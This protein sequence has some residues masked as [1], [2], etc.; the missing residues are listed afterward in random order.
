MIKLR[1]Y[2][3]D[4]VSR[5][6]KLQDSVLIAGTGTGKTEMG[7]AV[8]WKRVQ[9]SDRCVFVVPRDNL[10]RQTAATM[11]RWGLQCGFVLGGTKENRQA[12]IQIISYQSLG[13]KSRD[14]S[15][16]GDFNSWIADE[17]HITGFCKSLEPY[18]KAAKF[19]LGLTAT[20]WQMEKRSLLEVFDKPIFAPQVREMIRAGHLTQPV[21]F[22]PKRKKR[23]LY[24][25]PDFIFDTWL[26]LAPGEPSFIF[27]DS[28]EQ[29]EAI[30]EYFQGQGYNFVSITSKTPT[31]QVEK[32]FIDFESGALDGLSSCNKLAEGCDIPRASTVMLTARSDSRSA[33]YQRIGRGLRLHPSKRFT[34]VIDCVGVL[35]KFPHPDKCTITELDFAYDD[36]EPGDFP[37]KQCEN[38]FGYCHISALFCPRCKYPFDIIGQERYDPEAVIRSLCGDIE[39]AAIARYHHLLLQDFR[40]NTQQ[41]TA[42]FRQQFRYYPY[43]HWLVD[44]KLPASMRNPAVNELWAKFKQD[45]MDTLPKNPIQL[46]L[47]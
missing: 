45:V 39:G 3:K 21:Y 37:Q 19:K 35:R 34:R 4:C 8:S 17:C 6:L 15:W 36:F 40:Q 27:A 29:S 24:A 44:A 12:P 9:D 33:I 28:I 30:A 13:S 47:F 5:A 2:Q 10:A 31:N 18:L 42:L 26:D 43:D 14:L 20:P 23:N 1:P 25:D 22:T 16:L 32:A 41:S 7:A 46:D 11:K 38:C